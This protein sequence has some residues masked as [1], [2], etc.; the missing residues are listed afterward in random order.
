MS[1]S[2]YNTHYGL[3][4]RAHSLAH[5][6]SLAAECYMNNIHGLRDLTELGSDERASKELLLAA[7][8]HVAY[9]AWCRD[10][11]VYSL[12]DRFCER[13]LAGQCD[14]GALPGGGHYDDCDAE[15]W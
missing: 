3:S 6:G 11:R 1:D 9:C 8:V 5:F 14:C 7:G 4:M 10:G 2:N 12:E 13:C 15:E